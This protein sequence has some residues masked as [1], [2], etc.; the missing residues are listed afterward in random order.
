MAEQTHQVSV[1]IIVPRHQALTRNHRCLRIEVFQTSSHCIG[2]LNH[3]DIIIPR[4]Y[5]EQGVMFSNNFVHIFFESLQHSFIDIVATTVPHFQVMRTSINDPSIHWVRI[6]FDN[7]VKKFISVGGSKAEC[8]P[9]I[10]GKFSFTIPF[11]GAQVL[12]GWRP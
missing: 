9:L 11:S 4:W 5:T 3:G 8:S 7:T 12:C 1:F 6:A 2:K 10:F